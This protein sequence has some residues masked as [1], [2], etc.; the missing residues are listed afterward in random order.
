MNAYM[1]P[2]MYVQ[3]EAAALSAMPG[4]IM[5]MYFAIKDSNGYLHPQGTFGRHINF[6]EMIPEIVIRNGY[7]QSIKKESFKNLTDSQFDELVSKVKVGFHKNIEVTSGLGPL[8]SNEDLPGKGMMKAIVLPFQQ[9]YEKK[10]VIHQVFTA[11]YNMAG[12]VHDEAVETAA[13]I[14]LH[15]AYEGTILHAS[16]AGKKKVYLTLIGGGVFKNPLPLI[17]AAIQSVLD[18]YLDTTSLE[19][20]ILILYN[21]SGFE[22]AEV[23]KLRDTFHGYVRKTGGIYKQY[24]V[25]GEEEYTPKT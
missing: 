18:T 21:M 2:G 17:V 10:Q 5:R 1:S 24:T 13:R 3:G 11:A 15:A 23:K 7:P 4:A 6:L 20:I 9:E 22:F 14:M 19:D 8:K 25:N 12:E 16:I